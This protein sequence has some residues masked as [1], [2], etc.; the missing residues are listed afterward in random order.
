[1]PIEILMPALSPTMTEGNLAKWVKKEGDKVKSGDIIAE[2]ETDKATMEV[3]A[4][5]EGVIGKIMVQEGTQAVAV[6]SVIALLLEEGE[7]KK[8][9]DSYKPKAAAAPVAEKKVEAVAA[10]APVAQAAP[11]ALAPA[12]VFVPAAP[13][14]MPVAAPMAAS[15]G[16]GRVFASPLAKRVAAQK[17]VDLR[18][19]KGSGPKG[20]IVRHDV[21]HAP[22]GGGSRG[23]VM[24]NP[25]EYSAVPNNNMRKVIAKRLLESKQYVPHFY[26]TIDCELD[27]L[28]EAR[29]HLNEAA[30][31]TGE[32]NPPRYKLSVNDF[33]IKAVA[34]AL[35]KVPE[36]NATW[37]D[38]AILRYNNVDVSVAVAI[39]GGLITPIVRNA[40]QKDLPTISGEM[41]T[42][43]AKARAGKLQPEE[44]QGGGFS[45]SNL[46]MYGIKHFNA[47]INPPQSA[48]L[49]IGTGEERVVVKD[50]EFAVS[51]VMTVTLSSDHRVVDGA[52]GA[53]FLA[54]FKRYIEA[55]VTMLV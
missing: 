40:D 8:A 4:V 15:S 6:N 25:V 49:A 30:A 33:I 41:K 24:R 3:E 35:R 14:A 34:M 26:L 55:P 37:T 1:M 22:A 20:R 16:G 47:I 39:D 51:Q 50:G 19:V 53:N 32:G 10:A 12:P 28:L 45:I 52:V 7:D 11:K 46:G 48:I 44:F 38:E 36:A 27:A 13:V 9:L 31:D 17:G 42:L 29:E 5:D 2:I 18:M 23:V 43:A 21:E 54:A